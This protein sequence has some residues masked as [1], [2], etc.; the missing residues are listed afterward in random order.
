MGKFWTE[1]PWYVQKG[2]FDSITFLG[3]N[4]LQGQKMSSGNGHQID[5]IVLELRKYSVVPKFGTKM[6]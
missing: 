6:I 5:T 4:L 1:V 3:V 2:M